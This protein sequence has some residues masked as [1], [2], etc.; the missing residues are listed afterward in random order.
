M[1][2]DDMSSESYSRSEIDPTDERVVDVHEMKAPSQ[3]IRPKMPLNRQWNLVANFAGRDLKA[4]FNGTLLGWVWSLV[5]P[6]STLLIYSVV[7]SVVFRIQ[8]PQLGNGND[9]IFALWLFAGLILWSFF[10]SSING[11]MNALTSSGG[12]LSK[13]YFPAYAPVLGSGLAVGVQSLIEVGIL[14]GAFVIVG[15]IGWTWLLSPF[16]LMLFVIFTQAL[17][18]V[19]SILNIFARD[20]AHLIN[21]ALQL[22]FYMTPIIYTPALLPET[23]RGLPLRDIIEFSPLAKFVTLFRSTIY[24][25]TTG[26]IM[27][28]VSVV[29]WT[30]AAYALAVWVTKK[31]GGDLAEQI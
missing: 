6:M 10:S 4:K 20:L 8:P 25:L 18:V 31:R 7:F 30:L 1:K 9:G 24:D 29:L 3:E 12:L 11:G 22:L 27:Q 2:A 21:V 19:L 5:V 28:W 15:N 26:T 16:V 23:W 17:A 14:L 13:I